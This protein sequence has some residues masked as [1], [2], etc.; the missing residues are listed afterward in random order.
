MMCLPLHNLVYLKRYL[1]LGNRGVMQEP[2]GS[3]LLS[4]VYVQYVGKSFK[5]LK[6][7]ETLTD[8]HVY[9]SVPLSLLGSYCK[10]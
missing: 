5:A 6:F 7:V 2:E 3:T 1:A 4:L 8:L 9:S 10:V